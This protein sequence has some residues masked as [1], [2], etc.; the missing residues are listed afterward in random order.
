MVSVS[1]IWSMDGTPQRTEANSF[2]LK[3]TTILPVHFFIDLRP[4]S[5]TRAIITLLKVNTSTM[6]VIDFT[7]HTVMPQCIAKMKWYNNSNEH[8]PITANNHFCSST[9]TDLI[10]SNKLSSPHKKVKYNMMPCCDLRLG[11]KY[12]FIFY[13]NRKEKVSLKNIYM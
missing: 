8:I 4:S 10:F 7:L 1:W 3:C 5:H 9:K 12:L 13:I 11:G 6:K 2:C